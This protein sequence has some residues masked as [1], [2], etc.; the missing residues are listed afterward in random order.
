MLFGLVWFPQPLA[1]SFANGDFQAREG[2]DVKLFMKL[3]VHVFPAKKSPLTSICFFKTSKQSSGVEH[4]DW[5]I[6]WYQF[7]Y[8]LLFPSTCWLRLA[9]NSNTLFIPDPIS[10]IIHPSKKPL[11]W[12][13]SVLHSKCLFGIQDQFKIW[14]ILPHL[15]ESAIL[16]TE[17]VP[18]TPVTLYKWLRTFFFIRTRVTG[19][20]Y[21]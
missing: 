5:C 15:E 17:V 7:W 1:V 11:L 9:W 4:S 18:V 21:V 12:S 6:S 20:K 10:F 8:V 2:W 16:S 19:G 3:F 13:P 14:Y